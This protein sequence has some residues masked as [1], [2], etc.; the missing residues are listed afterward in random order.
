M[1]VFIRYLS[2]RLFALKVDGSDT[3]ECVKGKIIQDELPQASGVLADGMCLLIAGDELD[4]GRT[5]DEY[6]I[7]NS[8]ELQ[9]V[10]KERT[11]PIHIIRFELGESLGC[12]TWETTTVHAKN[13]DTISSVQ[14]KV[15]GQW[16]GWSWGCNMC[17][18]CLHGN[19]LSNDSTLGD[20]N[21]Q[22]NCV[23]QLCTENNVWPEQWGVPFHSRFNGVFL[24]FSMRG[25]RSRLGHLR[26]F[27]G[28]T[29]A[30]VRAGIEAYGYGAA[31]GL[32]LIYDG[33]LLED[34]SALSEYN[35]HQ[36]S[37][38]LVAEAC[39]GSAGVVGAPAAS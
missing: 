32:R 38:V 6:N 7:Q 39:G 36:Y 21:I 12:E 5:L 29:V 2:G 18:L 30:D 34:G 3:I 14:S 10:I 1:E 4:N 23:L 22:D 28:M 9:L 26:W 20:N 31:G 33:Q 13:T 11:F 25:G 27:D 17:C 37:V 35:V 8:S 19:P 24:F 16:Y 15:V